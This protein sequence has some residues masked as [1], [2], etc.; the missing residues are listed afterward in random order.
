MV[1]IVRENRLRLLWGD[2]GLLLLGVPELLVSLAQGLWLWIETMQATLG[3]A[4]TLSDL[5]PD[6]AE[7]VGTL[8]AA[9]LVQLEGIPRIPSP[10][11]LQVEA[12]I[13]Q[14]PLQMLGP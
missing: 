6:Y 14:M 4:V 8:L 3:P 10:Q 13:A 7:M 5:Q 9:C 1:A 2:Q 11:A 12:T